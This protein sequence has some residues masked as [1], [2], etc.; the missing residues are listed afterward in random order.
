MLDH[1]Q[2]EFD[3]ISSTKELFANC[4]AT[5]DNY[6]SP[7]TICQLI[8]AGKNVEEL[9]EL[10]PNVD[11]SSPVIDNTPALHFTVRER[12][13]EVLELLLTGG[14]D[15]NQADGDGRTGLHIAIRFVRIGYK[16]GSQVS[17]IINVS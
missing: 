16:S 3:E 1:T 9:K 14:A 4:Q 10:L 12:Q 15:I 7:K 13:G 8:K 6:I 2:S 17:D 5:A 11:L